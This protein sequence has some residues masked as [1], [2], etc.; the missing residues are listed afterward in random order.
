MDWLAAAKHPKFKQT[1]YR[2]CLSAHAGAAAVPAGQRFQNVY[3]LCLGAVAAI[4]S[5]LSDLG[6]DSIIFLF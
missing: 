3:Y 1:I 2:T 6:L 4:L 5:S